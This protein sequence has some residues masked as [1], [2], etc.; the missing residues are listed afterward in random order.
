MELKINTQVQ[1]PNGPGRIISTPVGKSEYYTVLHAT[2]QAAIYH[3]RDIQA[4]RQ[5][6]EQ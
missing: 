5:E 2:G 6:V 3:R 4:I 1:T